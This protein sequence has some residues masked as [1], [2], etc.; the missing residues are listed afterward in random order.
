MKLQDLIYLKPHEL[1]KV[2][3]D[4]LGLF[5]PMGFMV[6]SPPPVQAAKAGHHLSDLRRVRGPTADPRST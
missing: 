1:H 5:K 3:E 6:Q 4:D 2:T